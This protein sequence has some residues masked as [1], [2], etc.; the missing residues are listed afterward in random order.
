MRYLV[1][2]SVLLLA[3]PMRYAGA[4]SSAIPCQAKLA[5]EADSVRAAYRDS[6]IRSHT[7]LARE[8]DSVRAEY[9]RA[10]FTPE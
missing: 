4:Q 8:A 3:L 1:M 9:Y 7:E 5:H 6:I 2:W 10:S